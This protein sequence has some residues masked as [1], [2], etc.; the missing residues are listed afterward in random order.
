MSNFPITTR[1]DKEGSLEIGGCDILDLAKEFGTPLYVMDEET[2]RENCRQY[3]SAFEK[4]HPN[5]KLVYASKALSC[6]AVLQIMEEEGV[7]ADVVSGGEL[8][9]ALKAQCNPKN[10]YF[11][12]N[13]KSPQE[14]KEGLKAKIGRFVVGNFDELELLNEIASKMKQKTDILIRV[15]PGIEAHTHEFIQTAKVDSK[16]GIAKDE[17]FAAVE[18]VNNLDYVNLVGLHTHLG[19]Q[20]LDI[21]PFVKAAEVLMELAAKIER[22]E[23]VNLGGGLGIAYLKEDNPPAI[24]DLVAE[25]SRAKAISDYKLVLEPGRSLVGTAGV[26]LYS[27]GAVKEVKGIRKYAMVDGG[28]ADNIRPMLYGAVYGAML[29]NKPE[30]EKEETVAIAGRFC[31]SGDVLR[32]EIKL[33]KI[34]K[35]DIL[36]VPATGAY[37]YSMSSNYNRVGRPAMVL[38]RNNKA[39]MIIKRESYEDLIKN[40]LTL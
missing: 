6:I 2:M 11:H 12:G 15:N 29:V 21:K 24:E 30:A 7:G 19:S 31:E 39:K 13:N 8:Y 22:L 27:V 32:K 16:F 37:N 38:V 23:E 10:I 18:K 34:E 5:A 3:K 26:T 14:I 35:G 4:Y 25:I 20:I 1:I 40:D 17:I 33:P 28:M 36:A 9:T